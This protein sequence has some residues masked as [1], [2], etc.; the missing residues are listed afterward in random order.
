M[1]RSIFL[2]AVVLLAGLVAVATA[3]AH[4]DAFDGE[5]LRKGDLTVHVGPLPPNWRRVEVQGADLAFRDEAR[6][7]STLFSVRCGRRDDDAPLSVLTEHLIMGTTDR[8]FESEERVPLDGREAMHSILRAKL[9][10]VSMQ[11]EIYVMKKDGCL[12]D[13]VYVSSPDHFAEGAPDFDRFA[14]GVHAISW[15]METGSHRAESSSSAP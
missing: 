10:G 15:P 9:D 6:E 11:Y 12:Y 2:P 3:C 14:R 5:V 1:R 4:G 13:V 8:E 7:G